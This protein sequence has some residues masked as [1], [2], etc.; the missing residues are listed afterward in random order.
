MHRLKKGFT[1]IELLVVMAIIATLLSL[2]V[3]RYFQHV[4]RSKE[5][6]LRENL[7][8]IRDAIDQYHA[9]TSTWPD[10]LE[11]LAKSRYLRSLPQDPITERADTWL[12]T[13]P[14]DGSTGIFDI[15]SGAD[16]VAL[17]G[18]RYGDW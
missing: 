18:T 8:A 6:V 13:T 12:E 15:H 7:A 5:V 9:D 16:G 10:S 11:S 4:E 3:P 2:A 1:L 14:P 17:D